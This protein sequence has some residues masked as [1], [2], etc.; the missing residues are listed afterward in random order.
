MLRGGLPHYL[1]QGRLPAS[2]GKAPLYIPIIRIDRESL[3][4]MPPSASLGNTPHIPPPPDGL[5]IT[6]GVTGHRN[7]FDPDRVREILEQQMLAIQRHF[8]NSPLYA[9]SALAEGADCLFAEVAHDLGWQ[10]HA[11]LPLEADEYLND[12]SDAGKKKFRALYDHAAETRLVIKTVIPGSEEYIRQ[13][14]QNIYRDLQYAAVGIYIAQRSH[15]LIALWDGNPPK[16][17]GGTAQVVRFRETG[18]LQPMVGDSM[19]AGLSVDMLQTLLP[20]HPLYPPDIGVVCK[21]FCKRT[22]AS[23]EGSPVVTGRHPFEMEWTDGQHTCAS[24]DDLVDQYTKSAEAR[25]RDGKGFPGIACFR[26]IFGKRLMGRGPFQKDRTTEEKPEIQDVFGDLMKIVYWNGVVQ[27]HLSRQQVKAPGKDGFRTRVYV[28]RTILDNMITERTGKVRKNFGWLFVLMGMTVILTNR[29]A[30]DP[31]LWVKFSLVGSLLS[32]FLIFAFVKF[33]D[34]RTVREETIYLRILIEGLRIQDYWNVLGIRDAIFLQYPP[35]LRGGMMD[36][37]GFVRRAQQGACM[38]PSISYDYGTK[39]DYVRQDWLENQIT[40]YEERKI[41]PDTKKR[42]LIENMARGMFGLS[43]LSLCIITVHITTGF[44][45]ET[46]S[47]AIAL[48]L[49]GL[50]HMA[51]LGMAM[52]IILLSYLEFSGLTDDLVDYGMTCTLF[53]RA[54]A[55]LD[56]PFGANPDLPDEVIQARQREILHNLGKEILRGDNMRWAERA[57]R[58]KIKMIRGI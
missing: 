15:I 4:A 18:Y 54:R 22:S 55:A 57:L 34:W 17:L 12:F 37:M 33:T 8:P 6:I 41:A 31:A 47:R 48:L 44:L 32:F 3:P 23:A 10:V 35:S 21:V 25:S 29:A 2:G 43:V 50:E 13:D 49:Y 45:D 27:E 53:R 39:L 14:G 11:I 38:I 20:H 9:L 30:G 58:K 36:F 51:R 42:K 16:G 56:H 19:P 52:A 26:G 40:Y 5:P 7:L 28:T 46:G 1:H 24:L